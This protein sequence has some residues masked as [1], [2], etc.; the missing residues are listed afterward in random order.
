MTSPASSHGSEEEIHH[1]YEVS[2]AVNAGGSFGEVRVTLRASGSKSVPAKITSID[3]WL[4]GK[5]VQIPEVAYADLE[6]PLL[7]SAQ[8]RSEA[9][10]DEHPWL[11]I[12]FELAYRMEDGQWRPKRVHIAYHNGK[13]EHRSI[14][15]PHPDGSYTYKQDK[16]CIRH[17]EYR[18]S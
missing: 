14:D 3:L 2:L 12:Y 6:E 16:L 1:P 5:N 13:I 10:Y 11:Y 15:T 7:G 4:N 8:I 17:A 9:G 18:S